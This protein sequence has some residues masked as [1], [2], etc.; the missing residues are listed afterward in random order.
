MRGDGPFAAPAAAW[1]RRG[2]D[3]DCDA[4]RRASIAFQIEAADHS[5]I[6]RWY[7]N[8]AVRFP[9]H[10]KL[11]SSLHGCYTGPAG[12]PPSSTTPICRAD[13]WVA[14]GAIPASAAGV[15]VELEPQQCPLDPVPI[16]VVRPPD[17]DRVILLANLPA[18]HIVPD[19]E[20]MD[21]SMV[22][23]GTFEHDNLHAS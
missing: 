11:T 17:D 19:R 10:V 16:V 23:V 14:S 21:V 8:R 20:S 7:A 13:R 5:I 18:G 12:V 9:D 15:R 2:G 6:G 1:A 4:L 22:F 3:A